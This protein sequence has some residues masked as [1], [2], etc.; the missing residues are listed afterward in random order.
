MVVYSGR[1]LRRRRAGVAERGLRSG[2]A[3]G[4]LEL[5]RCHVRGAGHEVKTSSWRETRG[6]AAI[7][8]VA[9]RAIV[10]SAVT[11]PSVPATRTDSV[12]RAGVTTM[13]ENLR[14][15][16]MYPWR[17]QTRTTRRWPS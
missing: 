6:V 11:A 1:G 2:E 10:Q 12:W 5:R 17:I 13:A 16:I 15:R 3:D 7:C 8:L 4:A 14:R 9:A